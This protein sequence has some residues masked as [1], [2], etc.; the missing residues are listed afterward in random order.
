MAGRSGT[1]AGRRRV[2]SR[3]HRRRA[4]M[5]GRGRAHRRLVLGPSDVDD[6]AGRVE[7]LGRASTS[8]CVRAT[9]V[10]MIQSDLAAL[11]VSD[12]CADRDTVQAEAAFSDLRAKYCDV[13]AEAEALDLLAAAGPGPGVL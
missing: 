10:D 2:A 7:R 11:V 5:D 1:G 12:A 6:R 4:R 13:V 9:A 3:E 8:G